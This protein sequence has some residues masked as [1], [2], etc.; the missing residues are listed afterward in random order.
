MRVVQFTDTHVSAPGV[1]HFGR[2]SSRYLADAVAAVNALDP[3]PAYVIVTGDLVDYGV[4]AEY[5]VFGSVMETLA[6]PYYVIPGNHDQRDT[7]RALLPPQTYGYTTGPRSRFVVDAGPVRLIALDTKRGRH[8]PGAE[9]TRDDLA[10]LDATL[11]AEP[12]RPTVVAVHQPPFSSGLP[13]LDAFGFRR[14]RSLRKILAKHANVGRVIAGHIHHIV[15]A[16][17]EHAT[18]LTGPS[19]VPQSIPLILA[20]GKI[21]G[22]LLVPA[23]F[24]THDWDEASATF[25]TTF[26]AR[27]DAG[28]YV[29]ASA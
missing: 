28:E 8:W 18:M 4:D 15:R 14:A 24:A 23:G 16:T 12:T 2:D 11:A 9:L 26:Y 29:A 5:V 13:Y 25:V 6:V 21:F 17:W 27:N 7:M 1:L 10:W 20:K 19:S 22:K 3:K